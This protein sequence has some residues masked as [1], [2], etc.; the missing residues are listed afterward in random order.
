MTTRFERQEFARNLKRTREKRG[1]RPSDLAR[2][3]WGSVGLSNGRMGARWRD[4][5][6][7]Y[8]RG[9]SFP[10]P[11]KLQ[12]LANALG[13]TPEILA[14]SHMSI[15]GS[16]PAWTL[17]ADPNEQ[18]CVLSINNKRVPAGVGAKIVEMLSQLDAQ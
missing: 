18:F 11:E 13:T 10:G 7:V 14:P 6:S 16:G 15:R 5:I 1:M 3:A 2:A 17:E 8:E 12:A 4:R 9:R